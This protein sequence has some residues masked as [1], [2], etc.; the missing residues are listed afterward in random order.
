VKIT[1]TWLIARLR[2]PRDNVQEYADRDGLGIR[3]SC[4]GK[5]VFQMRFRFEGKEQRLDLGSYPGMKLV[6]ARELNARLRGKLEQGHDPR[7]VLRVERQ[8]I[9]ASESYTL[10]RLFREWYEKYAMKMK[11]AHREIL[12][13]FEIHVLPNYGGLPAAEVTL[14]HW[15]D[16]L[17]KLAA[18]LP[19]IA[20]RL[21]TNAKQFL[22]WGV[23]RK[24]IVANPLRDITAKQDLLIAKN[25]GKRALDAEEL[26][27]V[28]RAIDESHVR[29]LNKLFLKLCL[30]YGC[31]NTELRKART[32]DFDLVDKV[33]TVPPENHKTG[34]KTKKPLL[35]PI[36]PEIE[37]L[38]REALA[39]SPPE[40]EFL[41][42]TSKSSKQM[43]KS[44]SI[45]CLPVNLS[46]WLMKNQGYEIRPWSVKALRKTARTNFSTLAPPHVAEKMLGHALPGSWEVYDLHPYLEE[47]A[48]AYSGWCHRI[49]MVTSSADLLGWDRWPR[50]WT[51]IPKTICR[52]AGLR[53]VSTI[54]RTCK[55]PRGL[56]SNRHGA[57]LKITS[58]LAEE[59]RLSPSVRSDHVHAAPTLPPPQRPTDSSSQIL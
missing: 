31:R 18:V 50:L 8:A 29:P 42:P 20:D 21:L 52:E 11:P 15:L 49:L 3:I 25:I 55:W 51:F 57:E 24:I 45:I 26:I 28:W 40:S 17:E 19:T 53:W 27:R 5:I 48:A 54:P 22:K 34:K 23:K 30:I 35:R 43:K 37:P 12:R 41:F 46:A 4:K 47:Q 1:D 33:W 13:S 6:E 39:W 56:A 32:S 9:K 7:V 59:A 44:T 38:I 14:H 58:G 10:E 36:P 2:K 16:L